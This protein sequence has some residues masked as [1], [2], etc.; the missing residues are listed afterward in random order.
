MDR[1]GHN[2]I[3]DSPDLEHVAIARHFAVDQITPISAFLRLRP[4]GAHTLLESVEGYDKVARYSFIAIGEWARLLEADGQAVLVGPEGTEVADDPLELIR[5]QQYRQR[6]AVPEDVKWPYV[7]G[8]I[9]YFGYDWIRHLENLPRRHAKRGPEWEWVWPK[10]VV[11]FD[12]RKQ[13][14]AVVVESVRDQLDQAFT[15]MEILLDALRQPLMLAEPHIRQLTPMKSNMTQDYYH[16][17][18]ERTKDY[19][20]AGDIF[21]A[22]LSQALTTRIA[23]D[24]FSLYRKLRHVNPSPYLFYLETPRRT[25]AGSSPEALVRVTDNIAMNRPIAG[26]RRRGGN[27]QEDERLWNDLINDPKEKAEHVMLVDLARNDLGRVCEYGSITV[28]QF[29]TKEIYSHVMHIV[30]EIQGQLKPGFDALDALA[31][32]FPAGTLTGAP[33]IRAMEIIEELEPEARG[34]YGGVV[35]YFSHRGNLDACITIRTLD[36]MGDSVTVQAGGGIVADSEVEFEFQESMNKA[37]AALS[38]LHSSE[39]EW[40]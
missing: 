26:T 10:A 8:A 15:R 23:G 17:M 16:N 3:W 14:V 24:P 40:L 39:E 21:Q 33:K 7:G 34:S 36:I 19:I 20:V 18:I 25:L 12:H 37:A 6:I 22:V 28:S 32:C 1:I 2:E 5:R 30:S 9:G 4:F 13:E 31:A 35:G 29:M 27:S 38:V 11:A